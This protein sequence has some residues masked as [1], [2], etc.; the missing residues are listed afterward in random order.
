MMED[1]EVHHG[2]QATLRRSK[3]AT[4]NLVSFTVKG[5]EKVDMI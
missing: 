4:N 2:V 3:P 1:K 5:D